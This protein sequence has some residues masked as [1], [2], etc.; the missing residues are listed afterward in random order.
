MKLAVLDI[1]YSLCIVAF[2]VIAAISDVRTQK[3][4]NKLTVSA[5]ALALAFHVAWGSW[6]GGL[7]G[8][9]GSWREGGLSFALAGFGVG[10]GILFVLWLIGGGGGG[11]VK[12]MGALGAWLG[13][14]LTLQVFLASAVFVLL[15]SLV[16]IVT[17]KRPPKKSDKAKSP[18]GRRVMP[19]GVPV[20]LAT[21]SILAFHWYQ[22]IG[23]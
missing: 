11:D 3:L 18:A 12:L 6:S 16:V 20:A 10:F 8:A 14:V 5:F 21:W 4:P 17:G 1:V 22:T 19:F 15:F 2:T 23:G 7:G 13:P 9:W